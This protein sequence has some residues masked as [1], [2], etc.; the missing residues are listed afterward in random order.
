MSVFVFPS[1]KQIHAGFFAVRLS[2]TPK[3]CADGRHSLN[4]CCCMERKI[5]PV[6]ACPASHAKKN[7]A[8]SRHAAEC[9]SAGLAASARKH[10]IRA[11]DA[12]GNPDRATLLS[13][14]MLAL[15][16]FFCHCTIWRLSIPCG[17]QFCDNRSVSGSCSG[18]QARICPRGASEAVKLTPKLPEPEMLRF[19]AYARTRPRIISLL[20]NYGA[21]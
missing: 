16:A 17:L 4:F 2:S 15:I 11:D 14:A 8:S 9:G 18:F 5:V 10:G 13:R 7:H 6:Q 3:T 19:V 1:Q 21:L 20:R 12:G